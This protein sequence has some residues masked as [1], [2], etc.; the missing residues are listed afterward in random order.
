MKILKITLGGAGLL[1]ILGVIG[2]T[3]EQPDTLKQSDVSVAITATQSSTLATTTAESSSTPVKIATP[4]VVSITESTSSNAP[5]YY[6]VV[7][8]V[9]GDTIKINMN[10]STETIRMIGIDT[11]ETVD[12]RKTVQCFGKE[13]SN[14]AKLLLS[15][16]KVFIEMD[17]TQGERDKYGRL[18]AYVYR[19]DGLFFNDYMVKEGYAHEYTYN[20]PYKYQ[21][22]FKADQKA[23]ELAQKGLWA[24]QTCNGDTTTSATAPTISPT[25]SEPPPTP[26]QSLAKYYT[27]SYSTSKY[28]YPADCSGWKSLSPSYLKS[29]D[30]L[31][32]L[33]AIYPS[34]TLSPQCQ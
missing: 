15:G 28:Y 19:D 7:Q 20:A 24:P 14:Q 23:A 10:G 31:Q 32:A 2:S 3:N 1:F 16:K 21:T 12:P 26:A 18:L 27:S 29:F 34:K 8:V 33:L 11:P 17:A 25:P 30:T 13:A 5:T 9:D 22:Q 4:L 6:F